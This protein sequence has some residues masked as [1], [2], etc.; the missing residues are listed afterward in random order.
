[1][2]LGSGSGAGF[3]NLSQVLVWSR[4][5]APLLRTWT[6]IHRLIFWNTNLFLYRIE[7]GNLYRRLFVELLMLQARLN[8]ATHDHFNGSNILLSMRALV[9]VAHMGLAISSP[10]PE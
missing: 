6:D 5:L 9:S 3:S 10:A 8:V 4:F 2:E 1:M 7:K